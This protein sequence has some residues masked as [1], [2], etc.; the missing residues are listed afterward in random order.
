MK[1]GYWLSIA[2]TLSLLASVIWVQQKVP[3]CAGNE[4]HASPSPIE[5]LPLRN[6]ANKRRLITVTGRFIPDILQSL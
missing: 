3:G 1:T 4:N 5:L 6:P 2:G